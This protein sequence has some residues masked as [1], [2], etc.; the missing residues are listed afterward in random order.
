[1]PPRPRTR[2][3]ARAALTGVVIMLVFSSV[4]A[5]SCGSAPTMSSQDKMSG[6]QALAVCPLRGARCQFA[7]PA[8]GSLERDRRG[9]RRGGPHRRAS[10]GE[11]ADRRSRRADPNFPPRP[12]VRRDL[13]WTSSFPIPRAATEI[14]RCITSRFAIRPGETVAA[15]R[16][17][18]RRQDH[19]VPT[20]AALLRS[21]RWA[22]SST[23]VSTSARLDPARTCARNIRSVP[24]DP[25]IFGA[26]IADN[27]R[28]GRPEATVDEVRRAAEQAAADQFIRML[29]DGYET[30]VGERGVTLS[31]G[32]RQRIAIARAILDASPATV[33]RRGDL[34]PRCRERG[35]WSRARWRS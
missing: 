17:V 32:Q 5:V 14:V 7:R 16:A 22:A 19:L 1:M 9:R 21:G 34:R 28:Y 2:S 6:G 29:P 13:R 8:L 10:G 3:S 30:M 23:T 24:Q 33:A 11:A 35:A 25:V 27:I 4:V 20:A 15:R 31:G 26:T 18:G 12:K